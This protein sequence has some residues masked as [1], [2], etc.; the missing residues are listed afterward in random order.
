MSGLG[1]IDE[2][3]TENLILSACGVKAHTE[4][5]LEGLIEWAEHTR[6]NNMMLEGILDGFIDAF[7]SEGV[8]KFKPKEGSQ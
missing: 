6:M 5:E 3:E 1:T 2:E 7:V 4:E 8:V